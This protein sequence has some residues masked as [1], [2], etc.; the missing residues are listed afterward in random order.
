MADWGNIP[1]D[2]VTKISKHMKL[3]EDFEVFGHVCSCWRSAVN[4]AKFHAKNTQTQSSTLSRMPWLML[5][6]KDETSNQRRFYSF[7]NKQVRHVSLPQPNHH[8]KR[9]LSSRGWLMSVTYMNLKGY[10]N[11]CLINPLTGAVIKLPQVNRIHYPICQIKH[12][13]KFILSANPSTT[14]DFTIGLII[15]VTRMNFDLSYSTIC[16]WRNHNEEWKPLDVDFISFDMTCY[17]GVFYA[18]TVTAPSIQ[19]WRLNVDN[20]GHPQELVIQIESHRDLIPKSFDYYK[21]VVNYYLVESG[22]RLLLV[23]R[24]RTLAETKSFQVF[25]IDVD[26]RE[27]KKVDCLYDVAIFIGTH[28]S[29]STEVS[30]DHGCKPNSIYF[31]DDYMIKGTNCWYKIKLDIMGKDMGVYNLADGTIDRCYNGPSHCSKYAPF[32]WFE[33]PT[34]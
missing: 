3:L 7:Y 27:F 34:S 1:K 11:L 14:T 9:L 13:E 8:N 17:R 32:T 15:N 16:F 10:F 19:I 28:S 2:L 26:K 21:Y 25:E 22:D 18:V 30:I 4:E 20:S 29:F 5:P 23:C 6:E 12:F 33:V 24:V 31:T